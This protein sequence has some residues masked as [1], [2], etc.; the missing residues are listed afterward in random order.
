RSNPTEVNQFAESRS[1]DWFEQNVITRVPFPNAGLMRKVYPGFLQ[2]AGF[3]AMN[4]ERHV[5]AHWDMYQHLV[6]GDDESLDSKRA[7]Y[8]EY[9]SVMDLT[10]EF[11][12]QTMEVVFKEH[13][14]PRGVMVSRG[15]PV[16]PSAITRTALLTIEG[17]RDDISGVG[18]TRA[19]HTLCTG[20][21]GT[22]KMHYEQKGVGHYG[23]FNGGKWRKFIAPKIRDFIRTHDRKLSQ[24]A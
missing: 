22:M 13:H 20:L 1:L 11:Y 9:R 7:F 16:D 14:L 24:N 18:Q 12:M 23:I 17:E 5:D 4:L 2:L 8:E 19:A 15:R 6:E 10:A 3:L 21:P